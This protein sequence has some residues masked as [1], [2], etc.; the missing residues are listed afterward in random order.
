MSKSITLA[1]ATG[2]TGSATLSSFLRAPFSVDLTT[3]TRNPLSAPSAPTP[4][5]T[6]SNRPFPDLFQAASAAEPLVNAKG[7]FVSCLG[8]TRAQAGGLDKQRVVD[9]DLGLALAKKAREDGAE[10]CVVV[11]ANGAS[12][13]SF[14]EYSKMKGD[15][16]D[17][18]QAMGFKSLVVLRP[19]MLLGAR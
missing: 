6:Y 2:L 17:G 1:G 14:F 15:L 10:Q 13:T 19:G 7:V 5:S 12:K 18:L 3:V 16:E 9:V 8:T 11:T 4:P